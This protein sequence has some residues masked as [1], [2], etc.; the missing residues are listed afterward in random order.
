M[1]EVWAGDRAV[2]AEVRARIMAEAEYQLMIGASESDCPRCR[3][4]A[5]AAALP[6]YRRS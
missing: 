4:T 2:R 6:N 3:R 5:L 1:S